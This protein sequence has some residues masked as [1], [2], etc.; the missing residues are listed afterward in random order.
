MT[1]PAWGVSCATFTFSA[2]FAVPGCDNRRKLIMTSR[3]NATCGVILIVVTFFSMACQQQV[4]N[5]SANA[6]A[7]AKATPANTSVAVKPTEP[8]TKPADPARAGKEVKVADGP[9]LK[10]IEPA[11]GTILGGVLNDL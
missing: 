10:S 7:M 9:A 11:E 2:R 3:T 5:N 1:T 8:E 6:N 4:A